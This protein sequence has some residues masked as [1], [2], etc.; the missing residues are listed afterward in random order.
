VDFVIDGGQL[1]GK[2]SQIIDL[3]GPAPVVLRE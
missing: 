2:P 3:T 1:A